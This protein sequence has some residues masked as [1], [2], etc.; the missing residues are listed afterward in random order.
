MAFDTYAN[1]QTEIAD[2]LNR[3]DLTSAIPG[4][5]ELAEAQ[6]NRRLRVREMSGRSTATVSTEFIALPTDFRGPR[7]MH[8]TTNP[9]T[10]LTYVSPEDMMTL[11]SGALTGTGKPSHY[12]VIGDE[13]QI[14]KA[15][16][17]SYGLELTYWV[18]IPA[19]SATNTSNWLL[20]AHPDAYLYGALLQSAPYLGVDDRVGTW[21]QYFRTIIDDMNRDDATASYGGT[22]NMAGH[23]RSFG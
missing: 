8:L 22:L 20:D 6:L 15:P 7:T 1:L 3:T 21:G 19:L 9:T 13:F 18:N 23:Q 2:F 14:L 4:W 10:V 5:I 11:E 16:D 17:T 12:T